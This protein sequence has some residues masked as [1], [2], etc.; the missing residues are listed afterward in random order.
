MSQNRINQTSIR[1]G[2]K[3]G[4]KKHRYRHT[5]FHT[6]IIHEKTKPEITISIQSYKISRCISNKCVVK[7]YDPNNFKKSPLNLSCVVYTLLLDLGLGLRVVYTL[8]KTPLE[9]INFSLQGVINLR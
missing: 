8:R 5:N 1:K 6:Q 4:H 9:K 7:L 3:K 2:T